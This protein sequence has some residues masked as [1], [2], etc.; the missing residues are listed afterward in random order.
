MDG[1]CGSCGN[2]GMIV[3]TI[4]MCQECSETLGVSIQNKKLQKRHTLN[5]AMLRS[6]TPFT[7]K[8][9]LDAVNGVIEVTNVGR[10]VQDLQDVKKWLENQTK[11]H[12]T[13]VLRDLGIDG[14]ITWTGDKSEAMGKI[15]KILAKTAKL[16][17][18]P[19][20][21]AATAKEVSKTWRWIQAEIHK[22][23]NPEK[24]ERGSK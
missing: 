17:S 20:T 15:N 22:R 14:I 4:P 12:T 6:V 9:M 13:L 24:K 19:L 23:H 7:K 2:D 21:Y 11:P 18:S 5:Q 16:P 8:A 1:Y 3:K 10:Q